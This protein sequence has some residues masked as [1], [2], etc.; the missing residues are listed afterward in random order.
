LVDKPYSK[1]DVQMNYDIGLDSDIGLDVNEH[2]YSKKFYLPPAQSSKKENDEIL[3][4]MT[5]PVA[6]QK[7]SV[8][9]WGISSEDEWVTYLTREQLEEERYAHL[10]ENKCVVI[11]SGAYSWNEDNHPYVY[12]M[13]PRTSTT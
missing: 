1:K 6:S 13:P 5:T 2:S 7:I 12:T 8:L 9:K 3:Q 10:A 11:V 4:N